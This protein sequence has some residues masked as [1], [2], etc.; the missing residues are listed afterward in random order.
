MCYIFIIK[1]EDLQ[2]LTVAHL[3]RRIYIHVITGLQNPIPK[4]SQFREK[5]KLNIEKKTDLIKFKQ[6]KKY[7]KKKHICKYT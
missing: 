7:T 6:I 4:L 3:L 1:T 2:M 5:L